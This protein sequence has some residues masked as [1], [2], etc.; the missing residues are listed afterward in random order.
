MTSSQLLGATRVIQYQAQA[1]AP[2]ET[3]A[4]RA[5][6]IAGCGMLGG[7]SQRA[8]RNPAV[9]EATVVTGETPS[10][11]GWPGCG[12]HAPFVSY[13]NRDSAGFNR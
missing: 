11:F 9:G 6:V 13:S 2:T 12:G 8:V 7:T 10:I 1:S 5:H 3:C 4:Q